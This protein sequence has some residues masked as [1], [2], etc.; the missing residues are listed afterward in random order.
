MSIYGKYLAS[1]D[2]NGTTNVWNWSQLE[3][4]IQCNDRHQCHI[5]WHPW[6]EDDLAIGSN[7]DNLFIK[8]CIYNTVKHFKGHHC[9][10]EFVC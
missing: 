6:K 10:Q 9:Q 5:A 4:I 3:P 8:C 2:I 7:L 1:T